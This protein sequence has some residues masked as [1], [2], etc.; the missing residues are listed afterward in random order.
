MYIITTKDAEDEMNRVNS[1]MLL[2][3]GQL[4]IEDANGETLPLLSSLYAEG[5][6]AKASQHYWQ[7]II[8]SAKRWVVGSTK[9]GG[10]FKDLTRQEFESIT[11]TR[12]IYADG[13]MCP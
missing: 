8:S 4:I 9:D 2:L 13:P 5:V 3:S 11:H 6:G 7:E 12:F 1:V 10:W